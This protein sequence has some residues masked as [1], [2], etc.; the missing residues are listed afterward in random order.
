MPDGIEGAA[1]ESR[2]ILTLKA[3]STMIPKQP[4]R[5]SCGDCQV[6]FDLC[7]APE[8]EWA[9][10]IDQSESEA[11]LDIG[12]VVLCPLCGSKE[13]KATHDRATEMRGGQGN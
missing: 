12:E 9:E 2:K 13:I 4:V 7:V 6:V 8:S 5:F 3:S 11:N 1:R 10:W